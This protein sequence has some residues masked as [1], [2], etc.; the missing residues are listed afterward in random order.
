MENIPCE[1]LTVVFGFALRDILDWIIIT[2][3]SRRWREILTHMNSAT[4]YKK[5]ELGRVTEN[6]N[7][8]AVCIKYLTISWRLREYCMEK[9]YLDEVK[10]MYAV[11]HRFVPRD[12]CIAAIDRHYHVV[13]WLRSIGYELCDPI[14][15]W[16]AIHDRLDVLQWAYAN[17]CKMYL[18]AHQ[19]AQRLKY[20]HILTWM[21]SVGWPKPIQ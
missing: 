11:G 3:I 12:M 2:N 8:I 5:I 9:G 1:L 21:E 18:S 6:R 10:L 14:A 13:N 20:G 4:Q 15:T 19:Q 16:A 17:G 7:M